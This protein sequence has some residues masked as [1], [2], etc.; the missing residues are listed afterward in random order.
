MGSRPSVLSGARS[1]PHHL[2]KGQSCTGFR[3]S[4]EGGIACQ[5]SA[6]WDPLRERVHYSYMSFPQI[7]GSIGCSSSVF[8][9]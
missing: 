5:D 8:H 2:L 6:E 4:G 3:P 9:Y 7:L 1:F